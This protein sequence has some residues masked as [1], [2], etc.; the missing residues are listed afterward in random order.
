MLSPHSEAERFINDAVD[1]PGLAPN[2]P[3]V[4]NVKR[5]IG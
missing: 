2:V 3:A 4:E 5:L 1:L